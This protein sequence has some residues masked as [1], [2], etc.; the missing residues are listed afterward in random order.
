V[1]RTCSRDAYFLDLSL[2]E[3]RRAWDLQTRCLDARVA[4]FLEKDLI[5]C[6]EHPPVFTLGRRGGLEN[7]KVPQT[8]LETQGIEVIHVERGGDITYHGPGQLILYPIVDLR[9][10]GYKVVDF[11][12]DLEE[13]MIRILY[14]WGLRGERNSLNRG[15]WMGRAKIGSIG[16]A[17]RR[18][19]SFHGLALNVNTDLEPFGW[20]NPCGLAGVMVTSIKNILGKDI[21]MDEVRRQARIHA[22]Q[23]LGV[24]LVS[25]GFDETLNL[26][27]RVPVAE[28]AGSL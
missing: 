25:I 20:V 10:S 5:L 2:L 14:D 7:L 28:R 23:V 18:G 8:F 22:E 6:L 12:Q 24:R 3:Y 21:P 26:I 19:V 16:I 13:I 4:G 1:A 17:V 27:D 9:N 11:V 15:V